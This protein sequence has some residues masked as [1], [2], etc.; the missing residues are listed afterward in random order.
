MTSCL[1]LSLGTWAVASARSLA[2][3]GEVG[4]GHRA[5]FRCRGETVPPLLP[6]AVL[7]G[8]RV[9]LPNREYLLATGALAE[10][11]SLEEAL[12]RQSPNLWWPED[13]AWCVA[14]EIDFAWTYVAGTTELVEE[15]IA[16]RA[17]E[18][19]VAEPTHHV[20]TTATT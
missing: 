17:L 2:W 14:T 4:F 5:S 9:R 18:V 20:T 7:D 12:G 19:L 13:R 10:V 15:L 3:W 1:S 16:V 6:R 8:P 11:A